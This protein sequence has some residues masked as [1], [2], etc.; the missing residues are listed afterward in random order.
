MGWCCGVCSFLRSHVVSLSGIP[1]RSWLCASACFLQ[2]P[3]QV[4]YPLWVGEKLW[5]AS[6]AAVRSEVLSARGV[7]DWAFHDDVF[8]ALDWL[9]TWA[10]NLFRCVL[11]E[12]ALG[13]F[14]DQ[15]MPF[16]DL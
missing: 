16:Y 1:H 13:V 3:E 11:G 7:V 10:G 14:S 12:E 4:L 15:S 2:K 8:Y 6:Q 5:K 9:A